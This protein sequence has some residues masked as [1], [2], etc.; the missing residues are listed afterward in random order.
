MKK[1]T[2]EGT[3]QEFYGQQT[4]SGNQKYKGKVEELQGNYQLN[5]DNAKRKEQEKKAAYKRE[6]E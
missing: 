4:L 2:Q 5:E 3:K 6:L 1:Q